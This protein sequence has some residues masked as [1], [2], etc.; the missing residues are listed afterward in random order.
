M[1]YA[2]NVR[3]CADALKAAIAEAVAAGYRVDNV[4]SLDIGVSETAK[5]GAAKV[6][7][8]GEEY[9]HMSKSALVELAGARGIELP[10]GSTKAEIAALLKNAFGNGSK[11]STVS[12]SATSR[13]GYSRRRQR[14]L[15]PST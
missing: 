15:S 6:V 14:S 3:E 9:D 1:D 12:H 11:T 8:P 13:G 4:G 5:V 10:S 2:K 7:A